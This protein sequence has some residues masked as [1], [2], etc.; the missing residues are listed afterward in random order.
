MN[1][2]V[3]E[4]KS[5]YAEGYSPRMIAQIVEIPL[6]DVLGFLENISKNNQKMVDNPC[7]WL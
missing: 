1:E 7:E 6:W 4:I 3:N 5:L 2:L